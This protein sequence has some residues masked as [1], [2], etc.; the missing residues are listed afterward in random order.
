M[1]WESICLNQ[2]QEVCRISSLFTLS[3]LY[4][5]YKSMIK[6]G[7]VVLNIKNGNG[8]VNPDNNLPQ[9]EKRMKLFFDYWMPSW[10]ILY[11]TRPT[12][13]QLEEFYKSDCY[14]YTGH[15]HGLHLLS[16]K[17]V[18][19]LQINAVV[20][21]FGCDSVRLTSTGHHA[22]MSGSHL[23]YHNALCPAVI[24][25]LVIGLDYSM[26]LISCNIV[27][28][29][30]PSK[31]KL[32]W[33]QVDYRSWKMGNIQEDP[34]MGIS[35]CPDFERRLATIVAKA[36]KPYDNEKN[37]NTVGIVYRGLPVYNSSRAKM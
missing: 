29:W 8:V 37:Y 11:N 12:Q 4:K 2:F 34:I 15:G 23:Y 33:S 27:S 9:N 31:Q 35:A 16:G 6:N 17:K 32:H 10:N 20:F 14:I 30:I 26:D 7:Y 36:R 22:E 3:K 24:G 5:K 25:S 18:A 1:F 13:E 21:L 19:E 28:S